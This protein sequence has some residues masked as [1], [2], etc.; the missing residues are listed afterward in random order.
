MRTSFA[1]YCLVLS[2]FCLLGISGQAQTQV[3]KTQ[4]M[5]EAETRVVED[6]LD[7]IRGCQMTDGAF[8]IANNG[9][10]PSA[11][12]WIAPYFVN[13]GMLALLAANDAKKSPADVAR[14]G[15]WLEWCAQHQEAAGF[16]C[17]YV[18]TI[19]EY[20]SNGKVDAYDSSAAMF[21]MVVESY[22]RA[23]GK[24]SD[25]MREAAKRSLKCIQTVTD[26]RD[27]LT[28]AKPD[29]QVKFL[30]DNI[31]V[32]AG[33][34]YAQQFFTAKH[35]RAAAKAAGNQ[36]AEVGK[37]LKTYWEAKQKKRFAWAFYP[38]R[39]FEGGMKDLYP[40]GLA[41]LF[42]V[43]FVVGD[44]AP[45]AEVVKTFEPLN[46]AEGVG[47]ERYLIAASRLGGA[48]VGKWRTQA[49][50]AAEGFTP[51]NVYLFRPGL[52]VLGLLKGADWMPSLAGRN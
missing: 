31:E 47:A 26:S 25:K 17:D 49:V 34:A 23:G 40:H 37:G 43:S 30:M 45:F 39:T 8:L 41:Q 36:K 38:N 50:K 11:Q 51:Q 22:R 27:K 10:T 6:C 20:Q 2:L 32:Y 4:K 5:T 1:I 42:G 13:Y 21:L 33:L 29:Y 44:P 19:A 9:R 35:D 48:D 52:V 7:I 18:G 28:W 24:V 3:R 16:W 46:T 15:K 12:V 14:V